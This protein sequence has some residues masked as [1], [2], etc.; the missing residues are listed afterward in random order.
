MEK[1]K[2]ESIRESQQE[3]SQK[4]LFKSILYLGI[5][6]GNFVTHECIYKHNIYIYQVSRDL[7]G[8]IAYSQKM[9]ASTWNHF[10]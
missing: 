6:E 2:V 1:R 4:D 7:T 9:Y 8:N 10:F 3:M 5:S